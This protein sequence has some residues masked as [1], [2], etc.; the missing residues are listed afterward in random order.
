[1]ERDSVV[2]WC[3]LNRI[4][5]EKSD[6]GLA[7]VGMFPRIEALFSLDADGLLEIMPRGEKYVSQ[8]KD[9]QILEWAEKEVEWARKYD[10]R[11]ETFISEGYPSRLKECPDP[12]L[13][14]YCKGSAD[15]NPERA[16]SIVGTRRA[17]FYGK[18]S[19]QKIV[20]TMSRYDVKP[21]IVSGLALG[22]D[23]AAHQAALDLGIATVAVLPTGLDEIYPRKH[24][25]LAMKILR[26]G[27]LITDFPSRTLPERFTFVRRNRIIAGMSDAVVLVQSY[28]KGGGLITASLAS[29]YDRE[30]FAVPGNMDDPSFAGCNNLI[31]RN[32]A[33]IVNSPEAIAET[34]GWHQRT[35]V[36]PELFDNGCTAT[37]AFIL[38]LL[39]EN[40]PLP[41]EDIVALSGRS[42]RE[43]MPEILTLEMNDRIRNDRHFY[44]ICN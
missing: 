38:A 36:E 42:S 20:E 26:E 21:V 35:P 23:G 13:M 27:A 6:V 34:M 37:G 15:L 10:I 11:L 14:L 24:R 16:V 29:Q 12:P 5:A 33:V 31:Y 32:G 22:I 1:M 7:L 44:Y 17:S 4:F 3:A 18:S 41:L 28:A 2:Y 40:G 30:V 43:L 8:L 19:L 9:P 39:K 25:E